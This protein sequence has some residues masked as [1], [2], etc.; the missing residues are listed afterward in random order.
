MT[1][2]DLK[3]AMSDLL[4]DEPLIGVDAGRALAAGR[5]ARHA[6]RRAVG[7]VLGGTAAV[8]MTG[9]AI[10]GAPLTNS[11]APTNVPPDSPTLAPSPPS[12]SLPRTTTIPEW[13]PAV[14][15]YL[16]P[17]TDQLERAGWCFF[18]TRGLC[19]QLTYVRDGRATSMRVTAKVA[20]SYEAS[21]GTA[22][23]V[24]A[25][26]CKE[27]RSD[28]HPTCDA[29]RS[30]DRGPVLIVRYRDAITAVTVGPRKTLV[31][32]TSFGGS[33]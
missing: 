33:S 23:Q 25:A 20:G 17:Y 7:G 16:R 28:S 24:L 27:A 8:L 9:L 2:L 13:S 15:Q 32:V 12:S 31:T 6:R 21:S 3:R 5:S 29:L 18:S 19:T 4:A 14:A 26:W 1:D 22:E 10:I 30:T 11:A